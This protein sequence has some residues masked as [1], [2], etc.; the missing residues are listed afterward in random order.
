MADQGREGLLSPFLRKQ[1]SKAARPYLKGRVLD[2]G[3][4]AG[5]LA[6]LI[7]PES[8][9]GIDIDEDP[10]NRARRDFPH[11]RFESA[12][13]EGSKKFDTVVALAVIEHVPDPSAFPNYRNASWIPKRQEL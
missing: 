10:L 11:H 6:K 7:D 9:V 1:R 3:C 12:L 13:P 8:Y 4:G 5:A 2:V